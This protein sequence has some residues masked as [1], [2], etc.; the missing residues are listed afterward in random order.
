GVFGHD[1]F[2]V[3]AHGFGRHVGK[4][5]HVGGD[6]KG[7]DLRHRVPAV[8]QGG[9]DG[10]AAEI[11]DGPFHRRAHLPAVPDHFQRVGQVAAVGVYR[12]RKVGEVLGGSKRLQTV[13]RP[14]ALAQNGDGVIVG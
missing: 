12:F 3:G 9:L 5:D 2:I 11:V 10:G 1:L 4:V 6:H 13:Q 8:Q 14:V 7:R